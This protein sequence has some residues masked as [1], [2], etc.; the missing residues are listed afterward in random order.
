[1]S[2]IYMIVL[3]DSHS[4]HMFRT[5]NRDNDII[6]K[7]IGARTAFKL[8]AHDDLVRTALT[9]SDPEKKNRILFVFGEIDCRIHLITKSQ[10]VHG[11]PFINLINE[12]AKSYLGYINRLRNEGYNI[13]VLS[14]EPSTAEDD[15]GDI[16]GKWEDRILVTESLNYAYERY[17]KHFKIPFFDI[18][19]DLVTLDGHR[20]P[21]MIG[22]PRHLNGKSG[23]VF[24]KKGF[25]W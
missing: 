13:A 15:L 5:L 20:I 9:E 12:T 14:V 22:D 18:Y 6:R 7:H 1:M 24:I 10:G 23:E 2:D 16:M 4:E 11:I 25:D 19:S 3:G 21:E 17:C 8:T